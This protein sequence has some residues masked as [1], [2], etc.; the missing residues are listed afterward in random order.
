[1]KLKGILAVLLVTFLLS[2]HAFGDKYFVTEEQDAAINQ[3][4]LN[5]RL[6]MRSSNGDEYHCN[7]SYDEIVGDKRSKKSPSEDGTTIP[8]TC[9]QFMGNEK[10][11][12]KIELETEASAIAVRV[13][14][15][16]QGLGSLCERKDGNQI[17]DNEFYGICVKKF[18][19]AYIKALRT[20]KSLPKNCEQWGMANTQDGSIIPSV[21][22]VSLNSTGQLGEFSGEISQINGSSLVVYDKASRLNAI[23]NT[24]KNT[25]FFSDP[26]IAMGLI[27]SGIGIQTG[28]RQ[29]K[30]A[31]GQA[32]TIS[33]ITAKC[34]EGK[35]N[36]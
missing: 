9:Y 19:A 35:P 34:L 31:S 15:G 18:N 11:Q 17:P 8:W 22:R 16:E 7:N 29:V 5:K 23:I 33:V 4:A 36:Y 24:D 25:K 27:G 28:T 1:M 32:S 6:R 21:I 13:E 2:A 30:L 3:L 26:M 10:R 14:N 12:H 20:K